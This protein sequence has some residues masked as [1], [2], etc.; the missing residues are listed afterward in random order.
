MSAVLKKDRKIYQRVIISETLIFVFLSIITIVCNFN[1]GVLVSL[2]FL[3]GFLPQCFF[4]FFVLF[5]REPQQNA[6]KVTAL[7][8]GEALKLIITIALVVAVFTTYQKIDWTF[9]VGYFL[10][11]FFNN[12]L[13]MY[14]KIKAEKKVK[15]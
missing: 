7:Y 3:C 2:G 4:L 11:I 13:P 10:A 15:N 6:K 9:F 12:I 14:L 8:Y 1:V 5:L